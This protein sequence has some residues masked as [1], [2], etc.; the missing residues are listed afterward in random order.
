MNLFRIVEDQ[1]PKGKPILEPVFTDMTT[2]MV[3]TARFHPE[4]GSEDFDSSD[5]LV[6]VISRVFGSGVMKIIWSAW[7]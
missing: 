1:L 5:Q 3:T 2:I 6:D 4:D 7:C